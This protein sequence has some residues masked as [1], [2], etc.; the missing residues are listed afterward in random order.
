MEQ[1]KD[2][3]TGQLGAVPNLQH[4]NSQ[5]VQLRR[6]N[7]ILE[8][9]LGKKAILDF[10]PIQP[11]EVTDTLADTSALDTLVKFS[12]DTPIETGLARFVE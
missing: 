8:Q 1:H 5:S 6:Y 2:A 11:G 12:P 9:C 4:W 10:Q 3:T 7:E